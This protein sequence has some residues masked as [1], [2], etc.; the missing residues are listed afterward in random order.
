M[1]KSAIYLSVFFLLMG[2]V[3]VAP[4]KENGF[5]I[6]NKTGVLW[7]HLYVSPANADKWE[8][9]L[10]DNVVENGESFQVLFSSQTQNEK[11]DIK[12]LD[13]DAQEVVWRNVDLSGKKKLKFYHQNGKTWV[14]ME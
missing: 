7:N 8:E 4:A 2:M 6:V 3:G 1:Q 13:D 10:F 12:I 9:D 14:E 5:I 11:W